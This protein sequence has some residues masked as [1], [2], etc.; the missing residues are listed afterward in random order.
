MRKTSTPLIIIEGKMLARFSDSLVKLNA[1]K[2]HK[3]D[4]DFLVQQCKKDEKKGV[5]GPL[6]TFES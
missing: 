4:D 1:A 2:K 5:V 3:E 6:R